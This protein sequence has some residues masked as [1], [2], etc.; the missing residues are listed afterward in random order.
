[1]WFTRV[2]RLDRTAW[3]ATSAVAA[4]AW[5]S[6]VSTSVL[7]NTPTTRIARTACESK[8]ADRIIRRRATVEK[9]NAGPYT[10]PAAV[11]V[12]RKSTREELS[13]IRVQQDEMLLRWQRDEDGWRELPARAWPE[14]QP[15]PQ[16]LE[17]IQVKVA[18]YGCNSNDESQAITNDICQSLLFNVATAL[19]FHTI[20]P[21]AGLR[22]YETLAKSGHLDSM[23]A[24]GVVLVEGVG[25][26]R[27]REAEGVAWL[28]QAVSLMSTQA[29][30]EL[31]TVYYTGID[32]VVED[33]AEAAYQLFEQAASKGHVGAMFMIAD[34]L[35]EGEG[36]DVNVA[37]AI[38][39][40][41]RAAD[42]GHRYARQRIRELLDD[43]S[44]QS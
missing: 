5:C 20:D 15:N 24:C 33:D 25:G 28:Q 40:L 37:E 44:Y 36:T 13:K 23:V 19:V 41:Y 26:L 43:K 32:G 10:S 30:Y 6:C 35:I 38:P 21:P 34:C 1:M 4:T 39:L 11:N 9:A 8:E 27:N 12:K 2:I 17:G 22:Q 42:Q 7:H 29:L 16:Q 31:G 18:E 14:Y 3:M